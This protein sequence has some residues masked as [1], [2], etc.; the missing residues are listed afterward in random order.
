[1][2]TIKLSASDLLSKHGFLDGDIISLLIADL[3]DSGAVPGIEA[4]VEAINAPDD[5]LDEDGYPGHTGD[6]KI[7]I[8]LVR[9]HLAPLLPAFK[10]ID[11]TSHHNPV[12]CRA[13]DAAFCAASDVSVTL[14]ADDVIRAL[15]EIEA[16]QEGPTGP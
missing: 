11:F 14:D 1:M 2:K 12:R 16:R 3:E 15:E 6:H 10:I 5:V 8:A 7:L 13:E 4:R 9:Q